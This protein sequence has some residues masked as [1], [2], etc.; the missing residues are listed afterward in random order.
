MFYVSNTLY[1]YNIHRKFQAEEYIYVIILFLRY[2]K[3]SE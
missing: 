2:N 3:H 1:F